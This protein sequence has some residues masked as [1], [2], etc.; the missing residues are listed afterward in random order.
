MKEIRN[1]EQGIENKNFNLLKIV[2][3]TIHNFYVHNSLRMLDESAN[4]TV[5]VKKS[6]YQ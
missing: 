5:S 1:K 6:Q 4:K 2:Y 3:S